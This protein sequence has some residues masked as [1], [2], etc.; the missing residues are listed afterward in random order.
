[1]P[2]QFQIT[3]KEA[4]EEEGRLFG[5]LMGSGAFNNNVK[6]YCL[7]GHAGVR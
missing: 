5:C 6:N 7:K 4:D 3:F 2:R 1:M